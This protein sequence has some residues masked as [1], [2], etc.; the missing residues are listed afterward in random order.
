VPERLSKSL[1]R[2]ALA[3]AA[4]AGALASQPAVVWGALAAGLAAHAGAH[5]KRRGAAAGLIPI[6]LFAGTLAAL[7]WAGRGRVS[8]LGVRALAVFLLSTAALAGLSGARLLPACRPGSLGQRAVMFG[9][10]TAHFA[11]VLGEEARRLLIARRLAA[12]RRVGSG[13]FRSLEW[14]LVGL[15]QRALTRAERFYAAQWLRG[16]GQ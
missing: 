2:V 15:F 16:L 10:F 5:R 12:P 13:G 3:A 4:V 6:V 1:G 11:W 9:L 14:A 8:L 7:E